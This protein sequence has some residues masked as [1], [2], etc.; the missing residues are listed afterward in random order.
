MKPREPEYM[1]GYNWITVT[2]L[3]K[4]LEVL[5]NEGL[6]EAEVVIERGQMCTNDGYI[7][8]RWDLSELLFYDVPGE[9]GVVVLFAD[10]EASRSWD[11]PLMVDYDMVEIFGG[12]KEVVDLDSWEIDDKMKPIFV[13]GDGSLKRVER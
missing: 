6:G 1:K 2:E 13:G 8:E 5:E 7:I 9:E 10:E 12:E 3:R 11:D 4:R